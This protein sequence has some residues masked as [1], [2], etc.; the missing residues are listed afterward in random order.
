VRVVSSSDGRCLCARKLDAALDDIFHVEDELS[1]HIADAL[2]VELAPR[3]ELH[4]A[5]R[6]EVVPGR[7]RAHELCLEGRAHL[8]RD[9]LSEYRVAIRCFEEAHAIEP[10]FAPALAG[11]AD[12]YAWIGFSF[13]PDGDWFDR[14]VSACDT[15]LALD[16]D[17]PEG[18][19][20]RGCLLWTP[21]RGFDH[22]GA[23]RELHAVIAIRPS[24]D[25][26]YHALGIVLYHVGLLD[27]A[28]TQLDHALALGPASSATRNRAAFCRYLKGRYEEAL[29]MSEQLAREWPSY[30]VRYLT[31][32]CQVRLGRLDDAV[33]TVDRM[34]SEAPGEV[35]ARCILGLVF[36]LRGDAE[37]ALDQ[38]RFTHANRSTFG[39]FH[40]VEYDAACI[41]AL[42]G[43]VGEAIACLERAA[44]DGFPCHPFFEADPLLASIRGHPRYER[45]IADLRRAR[46]TYASLYDE[47]RSASRGRR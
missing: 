26:A 11:L 17:L 33:R 23:M 16:P 7:P 6:G 8:L 27:E 12:A 37:G 9:T 14:A 43:D 3:P 47:L 40:H 25:G 29:E 4:P 1:R 13:E 22:A 10:T 36:A 46:A 20:V 31:A 32:A 21:Q 34:A 2:E 15:A 30:W 44:G 38:V 45:L 5:V 19:Y 41:H 28:L 24:F 42:C 18:R 35:L 39:H